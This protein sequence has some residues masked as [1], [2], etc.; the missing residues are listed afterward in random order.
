MDKRVRSENRK[1]LYKTAYL[2]MGNYQLWN[3]NYYDEQGKEYI[4]NSYSTRMSEYGDEKA[5]RPDVFY[6]EIP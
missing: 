1:Q 2:Y 3:H 5:Q 6:V 4:F